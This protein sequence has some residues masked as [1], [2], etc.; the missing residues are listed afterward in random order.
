MPRTVRWISAVRG[1]MNV[2]E[3]ASALATMTDFSSGV[4]YRWCGSLPVGRRLTS[5][6]F[7]GSTTLTLPS[8]EFST[9]TGEA[10]TPWAKETAAMNAAGKRIRQRERKFTKDR[11]QGNSRVYPAGLAFLVISPRWN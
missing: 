9:K 6:Q 2:S 3:S 7:W 1:S 11:F 10:P 4:M 5:F 8:R